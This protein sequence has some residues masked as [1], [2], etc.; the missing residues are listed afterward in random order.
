MFLVAQFPWAWRNLLSPD[1]GRRF[2]IIRVGIE[3]KR[4]L[5]YSFKLCIFIVYRK[6]ISDMRLCKLLP[7]LYMT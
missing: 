3:H 6:D 7:Q 5:V 2:A 1:F 4:F